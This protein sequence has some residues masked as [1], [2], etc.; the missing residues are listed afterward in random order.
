M[1][2]DDPI[3]AAKA[4]RV[5]RIRRALARGMERGCPRASARLGGFVMLSVKRSARA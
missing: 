1:S 4:L 3:D 5:E 2:R